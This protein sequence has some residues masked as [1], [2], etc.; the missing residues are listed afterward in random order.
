MSWWIRINDR[1]PSKSETANVLVLYEDDTSAIQ[2]WNGETFVGDK[3][4]VSG[5]AATH[6]MPLPEAPK[7]EKPR[8]AFHPNDGGNRSIS[9]DHSYFAF[10]AISSQDLRHLVSWLNDALEEYDL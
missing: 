2:L 7:K 10:D 9:F 1:L 8:F 6:W 5:K 3:E 4:N